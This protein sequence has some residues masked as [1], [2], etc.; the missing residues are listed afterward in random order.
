MST[1]SPD[2]ARSRW[3]RRMFCGSLLASAGARAFALSPPAP[4]LWAKAPEPFRKRADP[5]RLRASA[6][7]GTPEA[8]SLP[9]LRWL[10]GSQKASGAWESDFG[11]IAATAMGLLALLGWGL[12]PESPE[13]GK[14]IRAAAEGLIGVGEARKGDFSSPSFAFTREE[15]SAQLAAAEEERRYRVEP[16][17]IGINAAPRWRYATAT[18]AL[19]EYYILTAD[20]RIPPLL[21]AAATMIVAARAENLIPGARTDTLLIAWQYW[22]LRTVQLAAIAV[23]QIDAALKLEIAYFEG[24]RDQNGSYGRKSSGSSF[25]PTGAACASV[26]DY[27]KRR[28]EVK[29]GIAFLHK[30]IGREFTLARYSLEA[31]FW[32][33]SACA[34]NGGSHWGDCRRGIFSEIKNRQTAAGKW[35][36]DWGTPKNAGPAVMQSFYPVKP[37]EDAAMRTAFCILMLESEWRY[38]P[39]GIA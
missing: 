38:V 23:P 5:E 1:V 20:K 14:T 2:P 29:D 34:L 28:N 11:P 27:S 19:A 26:L 39:P 32:V 33:T 7:K 31:G 30:E 37:G 12:T 4:N 16:I 36:G 13:F 25:G 15:I 24:D 9:G 21:S 3:S 17:Q 35:I 8:M 18:R 10:A 22:A 6:N